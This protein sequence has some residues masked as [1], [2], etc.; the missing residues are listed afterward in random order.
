VTLR[1]GALVPIVLAF[2][3]VAAPA[4]AQTAPGADLD[5]LIDQSR[6]PQAAMA[7]ARSL[8]GSGDLVQA[9]ATL[10]RVLIEFPEDDAAL[11]FHATLLCRLDDRAGARAELASLR[12]VDPTGSEWT[13]VT[14]ACGP[15]PRPGTGG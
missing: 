7:L 5:M 11:L 8:A 14:A 9:A 15:V 6:D 1:F 10:E 13:Q 4:A 12:G 2:C 3:C